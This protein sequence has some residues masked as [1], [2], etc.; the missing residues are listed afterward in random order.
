MSLENTWSDIA[1][2]PP[3]QA[4]NPHDMLGPHWDGTPQ[5]EDENPTLGFP[6]LGWDPHFGIGPLHWDPHEN[7]ESPTLG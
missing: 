6:M 1:L 5:L 4:G 7:M 3:C 2:R